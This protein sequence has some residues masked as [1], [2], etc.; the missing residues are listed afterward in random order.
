[1]ARTHARK[2][3]IAS[4]AGSGINWLAAFTYTIA[5]AFE[6]VANA[7]AHQA[8][9]CNADPN[10]V[11]AAGGYSL[12]GVFVSIAGFIIVR[13]HLHW[14]VQALGYLV[15]AIC[16]GMAWYSGFIANYSLC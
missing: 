6:A 10:F 13:K 5:L 1:M 16:L 4:T 12:A 9:S 7:T 11:G 3:K 8:S 15:I 14:T 2:T